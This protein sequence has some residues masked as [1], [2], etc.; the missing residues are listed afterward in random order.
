[1]LLRQIFSDILVKEYLECKLST[2]IQQLYYYNRICM[3]FILSTDVRITDLAIYSSKISFLCLWPCLPSNLQ[4]I[5]FFISH[6]VTKVL[7]FILLD[8]DDDACKFA[9]D[10]F[11]F[12][13]AWEN[14]FEWISKTS[15]YRKSIAKIV[16]HWTW[17]S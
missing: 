2:Q 8:G 14:A 12:F 15:I 9:W 4:K 6:D 13:M 7:Q 5:I 16:G 17:L 10:L 1:M 3:L 11:I